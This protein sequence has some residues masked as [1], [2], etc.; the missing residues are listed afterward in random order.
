MYL[1]KECTKQFALPSD[2]KGKDNLR[3][4][5]NI[6]SDMVEFSFKTITLAV[7]CANK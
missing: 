5:F 1:K 4:N 7:I 3:N 6:G 2:P